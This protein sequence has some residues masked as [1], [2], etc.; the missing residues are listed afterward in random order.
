[1][2]RTKYCNDKQVFEDPEKVLLHLNIT[3]CNTDNRIW[4]K[5]HF[6][7]PFESVASHVLLFTVRP[8]I[9]APISRDIV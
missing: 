7:A 6:E 9:T 4:I 8:Q 3:E 5:L 2:P 1:M